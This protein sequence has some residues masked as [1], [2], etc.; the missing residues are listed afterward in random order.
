MSGFREDSGKLA[1]SSLVFLNAARRLAATVIDPS[2][3]LRWQKAAEEMRAALSRLV[4][5]DGIGRIQDTIRPASIREI[6]R[7]EPSA[8]DHYWT[9]PNRLPAETVIR[10]SEQAA[11]L[12]G[13]TS[14]QI[15]GQLS[16]DYHGVDLPGMAR[17]LRDFTNSPAWALW[18]QHLNDAAQRFEEDAEILREY[19]EPESFSG[20]LGVLAAPVQV[21]YLIAALESLDAFTRF[22]EDASGEDVPDVVQSATRLCLAIVVVLCLRLFPPDPPR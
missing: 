1:A 12:S 15:T 18:Q 6:T 4:G 9:Y 20:F 19:P 21:A 3:V 5:P 17:Q 11:K 13:V 7:P 16:E 10:L 8:L 14:E 22:L 2:E